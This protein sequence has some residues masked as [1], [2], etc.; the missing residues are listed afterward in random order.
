MALAVER[1]IEPVARRR[2]RRLQRPAVARSGPSASAVPRNSSCFAL[3]ATTMHVFGQQLRDEA[4]FVG[5]FGAHH[6]VDLAGAQQR[7]QRVDRG[8]RRFAASPPAPPSA[9]GARPAAAGTAPRSA[10][11][12]CGCARTS[13][14]PMRAISRCASST[15]KRMRCAHFSST[16]PAAVRRMPR[17]AFSNSGAPQSSSSRR[18]QLVSAGC[19][20]CSCSA[21]RP[22][23]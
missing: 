12:R 21:A 3:A 8:R 17:P 13:R 1:V 11:C 6:Q 4:V 2:A 14:W 23:C 15:S 18:T 9:A 20:R 10:R 5:A 16:L 7:L 22:M 19:V